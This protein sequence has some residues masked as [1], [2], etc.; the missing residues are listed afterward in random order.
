MHYL[1]NLVRLEVRF[2]REHLGRLGNHLCRVCHCSLVGQPVQRVQRVLELCLV[3]RGDHLY[4]ER[5]C[6]QAYQVRL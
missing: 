2:Y 3:R 6:S 5:H 4:Q 1:C